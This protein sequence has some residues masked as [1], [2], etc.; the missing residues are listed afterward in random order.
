MRNSP[1]NGQREMV[2]LLLFLAIMWIVFRLICTLSGPHFAAEYISECLA[3]S[4]VHSHVHTQ[5]E[6]NS[7]SVVSVVEMVRIGGI[8]QLC[9]ICLCCRMFLS[10]SK[11]KI[12][13]FTT[14]TLLT[15]KYINLTLQIYGASTWS[16]QIRI[17]LKIVPKISV[18]KLQPYI[19]ALLSVCAYWCVC[20]GT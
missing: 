13:Y 11:N 1:C 20:A 17:K 15:A 14:T 6:S 9:T 8:Q 5:Q 18:L 2:V 16:I 19:L 3:F 10:F 7:R 12:V 4:F